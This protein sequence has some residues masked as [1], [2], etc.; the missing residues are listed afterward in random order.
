VRA[1]ADDG[2]LDAGAFMVERKRGSFARVPNHEMTYA[3]NPSRGG[4]SGASSDED[5]GMGCASGALINEE[6]IPNWNINRA[7]C[8]SFSSDFFAGLTGGRG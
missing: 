8:S 6:N 5:P 4:Q 1:M 2:N 3:A 7:A